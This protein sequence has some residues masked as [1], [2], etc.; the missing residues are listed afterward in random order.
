M[1]VH[2]KFETEFRGERLTVELN[3]DLSGVIWSVDATFTR[4]GKPHKVE[5][6]TRQELAG[7]CRQAAE[8]GR[9]EKTQ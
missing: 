7:L 2:S 5:N 3:G 8:L 4:D 9:K 1:K 6:L